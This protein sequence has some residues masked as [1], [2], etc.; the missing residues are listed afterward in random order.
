VIDG[1]FQIS[2]N[3]AELTVSS[4]ASISSNIALSSLAS[5]QATELKINVN[6]GA[7][8]GK[9]TIT[10][11]ISATV[12]A[13]KGPLVAE[14]DDGVEAKVVFNGSF[15]LD[16]Q[17]RIVTV[18][19][20]ASYEGV[21]VTG[22]ATIP[23]AGFGFTSTGQASIHSGDIGETIEL[24]QAN[25]ELRMNAQSQAEF[26]LGGK[27]VLTVLANLGITLTGGMDLP[28]ISSLP[29]RRP[30]RSARSALIRSK[31]L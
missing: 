5:A 24:G 30:A 25:F 27:P 3:T 15:S 9:G 8:S 11:E 18:S 22:T 21:T 2:A 28:A 26:R 12:P 1:S 19:G 4:A 14:S 17:K 10:L 16:P 6:T 13:P 7:I 29:V 20:S 23:L 31:L